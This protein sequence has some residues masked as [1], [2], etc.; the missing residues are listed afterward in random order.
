MYAN[1]LVA[2]MYLIAIQVADSTLSCCLQF[3]WVYGVL[4][5]WI[6][7]KTGNTFN[8]LNFVCTTDGMKRHMLVLENW[9][10]FQATANI[11]F[12]HL[13]ILYSCTTR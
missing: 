3:D 12:D 7:L 5:G 6:D 1:N 4:C 2:Y 9:L 10:P 11:P 13:M 8:V